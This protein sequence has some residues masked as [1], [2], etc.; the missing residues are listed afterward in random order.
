MPEGGESPEVN[1]VQ[2]L[3]GSTFLLSDPRGDVVGGS[4]GGLFHEDTRFLS[5]FALT[6][7]GARPSLL[8]RGAGDYDTA[9]FFLTNPDLTSAGEANTDQDGIA[10]RSVSIQRFRFVGDGLTEVLSVTSHVTTPLELELRLS[11]GADFADLFEVKRLTF[12]KQGA[13]E[14]RHDTATGSLVFEYRHGAFTAATR[15]HSSEP[16]GIDGDDLVFSVHLEPRQ[17]WKTRI[18]VA[19]RVGDREFAPLDETERA[20]SMALI[21]WREGSPELRRWRHEVPT[22]ETGWDLLDFVYRTSI[23][24][25]AALR[26]HAEVEGNAYSLPAAGLPWFMAIFGR[27]TIVTSYQSLLIGPDLAK[28]ALHA[29]AALQG[30]QVND[31]KDEEPGKILHEIRFGELTVLG[32]MPH[33]PYYGTNDATPLWLVLLSE[34]WRVTGDVAT[35]REL[36]PNA[37]RALEWIDRYGDRDGDGYVE[38][39]TRSERGLLNQGWKDSTNSM[40]YANGE[41]AQPPIATCEIQ[42]YAYDAKIRTA[43]LADKV[44][45]DPQLAELLRAEAA[46]LFDRFNADYWIDARG[47]YYAEALAGEPGSKRVVDSMTSSMG[48]LLWSGIVP[49]DRAAVVVRQLFGDAMF[50]GWGVRTMSTDDAGYNPVMYHDGTVWPHDNSLICAGLARY[51]FRREANRIATTMIQAAGYSQYRLPEVFAGYPR[52]ESGFP[53][54]YPTASSPQAWATA[55]PFLWLRLLLGA[56]PV[57]GALQVDPQIPAEVGRVTVRGLHAFGQRWNVAA[58]GDHGTVAVAQSSTFA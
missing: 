58:E 5:R 49:P 10:G 39:A 46:A 44:W 40:L 33:R 21:Q 9:A 22:V 27:D 51:G 42:G 12:N 41:L 45:G 25:L 30:T 36:Q 19:F 15:V 52:S 28:G 31:F 6:V 54:R 38:Y 37:L 7:N 56:D 48:H 26:L 50:S 11:C 47:G 2:I 3:K 17:T 43:E 8:S 4:L 18:Q 29:L 24:D 23:A 35:V 1:W 32:E 55:A 53:V 14:S 57:D 34:Y 13:F 20:A 16:A